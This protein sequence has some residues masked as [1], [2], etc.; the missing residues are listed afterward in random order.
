MRCRQ[1]SAQRGDHRRPQLRAAPPK[2][3]RKPPQEL[4]ELPEAAQLSL[5]PRAETTTQTLPGPRPRLPTPGPSGRAEGPTDGG[6]PPDKSRE[7]PKEAEKGRK[8]SKGAEKSR[9]VPNGTSGILT[10]QQ[11]HGL[12]R[13]ALPPSP[14]APPL[15]TFVT[16]RAREALID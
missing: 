11:R 6:E 14:P 16:L 1:L 13:S 8:V 15:R 7:R 2:R 9:R 5:R 3:P 4:T 12:R 10:S